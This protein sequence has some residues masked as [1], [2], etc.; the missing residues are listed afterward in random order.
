MRGSALPKIEVDKALV[1]NAYIFRDCLKVRDGR[2]I[3]ANRN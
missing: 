1:G 2:L 3:K